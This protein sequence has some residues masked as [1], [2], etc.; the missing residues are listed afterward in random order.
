MRGGFKDALY[1]SKPIQQPM[2]G[3][4]RHTDDPDNHHHPFMETGTFGGA[5]FI[6]HLAH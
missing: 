5:A 3:R 4:S 1:A 2:P 6:T